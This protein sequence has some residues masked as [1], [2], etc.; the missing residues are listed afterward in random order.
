[1]PTDAGRFRNRA[2]DCL[3]IAKGT[4]HEADRIILEEIAAELE[5]EAK[6]IDADREPDRQKKAGWRLS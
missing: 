6:L 3:N 5:A 2:K 4:R 1:M